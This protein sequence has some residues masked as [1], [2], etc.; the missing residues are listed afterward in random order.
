MTDIKSARPLG[1]K[2]IGILTIWLI[3]WNGLRL[4]MSIFYWN[5]LDEYNAHP[6]YIFLSGGIWLTAGLF[7]LWTLNQRKTSSRKT[8]LVV[9]VGYTSWYWLDRL[10]LQKPHANWLFSITINLIF[11]I[12]IIVLLFS[13]KTNLYLQRNPYEQKSKTSTPS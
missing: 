1:I 4:G 3:V 11:L 2:I 10:I 8:T 6:F 7:L 9:A 12:L 13:R 5:T